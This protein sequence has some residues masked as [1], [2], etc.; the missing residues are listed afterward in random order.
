MSHLKH[1][2]L[3]AIFLVNF[4]SFGQTVINSGSGCLQQ[5]YR[6]ND[7]Y[8][9]LV[10]KTYL[11][12]MSN[13]SFIKYFDKS[14]TLVWE[15]EIDL[16]SYSTLFFADENSKYAYLV[17][18]ES[19][20]PTML[21][22]K[23][24]K[25]ALVIYRFDKSGEVKEFVIDYE[26]H[27]G[28][29]LGSGMKGTYLEYLAV[30]S[31]GLTGVL[32]KTVDGNIAYCLFTFG[33]NGNPVVTKIDN[34]LDVKNWRSGQVSKPEY[35]LTDE[36]LLISQVSIPEANFLK[37]QVSAYNPE[38][39]G[40]ISQATN[41]V[42]IDPAYNY[43]KFRHVTIP[44]ESER[45]RSQHTYTTGSG[46]TAY[47]VATLGS[48][49]E[50]QTYKEKIYAVGTFYRT[51]A[52]RGLAYKDVIGFLY[53][54]LSGTQDQQL[55]KENVEYITLDKDPAKGNLLNYAIITTDTEIVYG[56]E[57]EKGLYHYVNKQVTPLTELDRYTFSSDMAALYG[58]KKADKIDTDFS[59]ISEKCNIYYTPE[60]FVTYEILKTSISTGYKSTGVY[61]SALK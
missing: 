57:Y 44:R 39:H 3:A 54:E 53:F 35:N 27:F 40:L 24:R 15:K 33:E 47:E 9:G 16:S 1:F 8:V 41:D 18:I 36:T 22:A 29:V 32:S 55:T 11:I 42:E 59:G 45:N 30:Y 34:T 60:G 37:I 49:L 20:T 25:N 10:D 14:K 52:G 6:W 48:L 61:W 51:D 23:S 31:G 58:L 13:K 17:N 4:C 43:G 5:V 7:G 2:L 12:V 21:E 26:E 50:F 56:V 19:L 46:S 28:K 38:N